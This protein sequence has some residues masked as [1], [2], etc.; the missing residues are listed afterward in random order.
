MKSEKNR[1]AR[2]TY[3]PGFSPGTANLGPKFS[4]DIPTDN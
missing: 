3:E 1:N 2:G 4:C